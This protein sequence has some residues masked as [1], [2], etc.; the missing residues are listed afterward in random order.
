MFF[1]RK[2]KRENEALKRALYVF[3]GVLSQSDMTKTGHAIIKKK[4]HS[5]LIQ[6]LISTKDIN[7]LPAGMK[8]KNKS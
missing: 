1:N 2:M 6:A 7:C 4:N 5:Y 8:K 3:R